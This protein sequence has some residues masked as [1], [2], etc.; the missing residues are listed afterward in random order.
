MID[1]HVVELACLHAL[2]LLEQPDVNAL[3]RAATPGSALEALMQDLTDA[4]AALAIAASNP[5]PAD[6]R[7]RVLAAVDDPAGQT[8][9]R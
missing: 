5:P 8:P 2:G 4:A 9:K 7:S 1:P 6:L 3:V